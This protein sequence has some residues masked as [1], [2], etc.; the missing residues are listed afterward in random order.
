MI[1]NVGCKTPDILARVPQMWDTGPQWPSARVRK[2]GTTRPVILVKIK[3][4]GVCDLIL[5]KPAKS[6]KLKRNYFFRSSLEWAQFVLDPTTD[7]QV[8]SFKQE[9]GITSIWPLLKL[10]RAYVWTMHRQ[11]TLLCEQ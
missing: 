7:P 2:K 11:R 4:T 9:Y 10:C 6:L 1:Q 3:S 8:I 5:V